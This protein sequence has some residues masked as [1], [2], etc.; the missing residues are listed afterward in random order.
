MQIR[1]VFTGEP[2]GGVPLLDQAALDQVADRAHDAFEKFRHT[3]VRHRAEILERAAAHVQAHRREFAETIRAEA[4]KPIVLAEAEVDRCAWTLSDAANEARNLKDEPIHAD[5]FPSGAGH[6]AIVRRVPVGVVYGMTPFNFPLNLA[7]HKVAPA[8]ACGC[9]VIVKPS[10]RTP[11]S[12]FNLL[13]AFGETDGLISVVNTPNSLAT[14]LIDHA[15]VRFVSFTGSVPIG[16]QVYERAAKARKRAMLELG[17]NAGCV[18]HED[19]DLDSALPLIARGAFSYAGQSCISVQRIFVHERIADDFIR[20]L[21]DYVRQNIRCGDTRN[22]NVLVGP[23]IDRDAQD[24]VLRAIDAACAAGVKVLC[25]GVASGLCIE[26]T[27]IVEAD[28]KL[29]VCAKEIFAPVAV[30]DRYRDFEDAL[31]RVNDS[32][33]GLQAGVFTNDQALVSRAF[34]QLEV[35]GVMINQVPTFRLENMPYG[36]VKDSGIG[37]E[38]ARFA[39][40]DM[41]ELRTLVIKK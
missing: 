7:A 10:P 32:P 22:R 19:A 38:G 41:T 23:M 3:T 28:P 21:V 20:R 30:I 9:A 24:H 40:Q 13:E 5:A 16:W 31:Q 2:A 18:V 26:P 34:A 25:G 4:G 14:H 27:V 17:G 8:I 39:M 11:L 15:R 35:G 6:T 36:G 37:R 29:D 33:F 12:A 1:D